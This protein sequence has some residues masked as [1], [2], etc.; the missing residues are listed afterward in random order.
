MVFDWLLM[1]FLIFIVNCQEFSREGGT[2]MLVIK[3]KLPVL[4][5]FSVLFLERGPSYSHFIKCHES[6]RG[7]S[8]IVIVV[9][10][11]HTQCIFPKS[12]CIGLQ[13]KNGRI[14]A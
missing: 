4:P 9:I 1:I 11:W 2:E 12:V 7:H 14:I 5:F 8:I 3:N 10:V 13:P 6:Y